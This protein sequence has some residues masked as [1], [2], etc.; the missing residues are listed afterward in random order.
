MT[1]EEK[2]KDILSTDKHPLL[3]SVKALH[4]LQRA[5]RDAHEQMAPLIR[6]VRKDLIRKRITRDNPFTA[7][8]AVVFMEGTYL[9][10]S[11]DSTAW[12][13]LFEDKLYTVVM[14][15]KWVS[16]HGRYIWEYSYDRVGDENPIFKTLDY[17]EQDTMFQSLAF[18]VIADSLELV[19]EVC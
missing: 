7:K 9:Y 1:I 5:Q 16:L 13:T 6:L 17:R 11:L 12:H 18:H 15:T 19:Y 10:I 14:R 4:D 3:K 2:I 8:C